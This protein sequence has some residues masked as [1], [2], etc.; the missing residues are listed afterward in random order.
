MVLRHVPASPTELAFLLEITSQLSMLHALKSSPHSEF[1]LSQQMALPQFNSSSSVSSLLTKQYIKKL[2]VYH[3]QLQSRQT[4]SL[5][6][7][8]IEILVNCNSL[9]VAQAKRTHFGCLQRIGKLYYLLI[10]DSSDKKNTI[11][12]ESTNKWMTRR[13]LGNG[14]KE[15]LAN[16][17][18]LWSANHAKNGIMLD[19]K[20]R[21]E[22]HSQ[23]LLDEWFESVQ[24]ILHDGSIRKQFSE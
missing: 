7:I 23:I 1:L 22:E 17:L 9:A 11:L 16:L 2:I 21:I 18:V 13:L 14:W 4:T 24:F 15:P 6:S 3:T 19:G 10:S 5:S 8:L 20:I 12:K